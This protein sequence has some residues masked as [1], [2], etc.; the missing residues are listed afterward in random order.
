MSFV[1]QDP[2][3]RERVTASFERQSFLR[4]LGARITALEPGCCTVEIPARDDLRQQHGHLHAG[5]TTTIADVAAGYAA[6]TLMPADS[7]V[8]SL[9][10]KVNLLA[11]ARGDRLVAR[12]EVVKPGRTATVVRADVVGVTA[13]GEQPVATMLATMFCLENRPDRPT[14][15]SDK[16]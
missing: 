7:S 10:F 11:P 15:P 14:D 3:F 16:A 5:V 1:A 2:N 4:L 12:A 9:E 6:Y 8:L 13:E